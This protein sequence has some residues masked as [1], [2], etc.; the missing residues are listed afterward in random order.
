MI[1]VKEWLC[2]I[3]NP[4]FVQFI[5]YKNLNF[6]TKYLNYYFV[7]M[8]TCFQILN[9]SFLGLI[10]EWKTLLK[11]DLWTLDLSISSIR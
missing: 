8:I 7:D 2:S 9:F 11:L 3:P 1:E 6:K 4:C 10:A 5:E